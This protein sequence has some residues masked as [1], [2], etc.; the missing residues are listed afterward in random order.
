MWGGASRTCM[1]A[2]VTC[3]LEGYYNTVNTLKYADRAKEIK[4]RVI[5]P[6]P[7]LPGTL[8]PPHLLEAVCCMEGSWIDAKELL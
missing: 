1:L 6:P 4:T 8:R 2:M 5:L 3:K 7:P